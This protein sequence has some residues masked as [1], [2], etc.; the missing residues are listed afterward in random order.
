MLVTGTSQNGEYSN[1]QMRRATIRLQVGG[2]YGDGRVQNPDLP[3]HSSLKI[4]R[5]ITG[6]QAGL[7][8]SELLNILEFLL[9]V[10]PSPNG[11][12]KSQGWSSGRNSDA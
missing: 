6:P 2:V 4:W 8:N 7:T 3:P 11:P 9:R 10:D 5:L 12:A 1:P